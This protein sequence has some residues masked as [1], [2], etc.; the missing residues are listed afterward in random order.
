MNLADDASHFSSDVDFKF[1]CFMLCSIVS[2][3]CQLNFVTIINSLWVKKNGHTVMVKLGNIGS[4][5]QIT[6]VNGIF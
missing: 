6:T 1:V 3:N 5:Y 4:E 2:F